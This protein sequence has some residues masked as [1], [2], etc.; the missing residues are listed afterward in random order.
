MDELLRAA[1]PALR[2][3][4]ADPYAALAFE[5]VGLAGTGRPPFPDLA[6]DMSQRFVEWFSDRVEY[7]DDPGA[8]GGAVLG[9]LLG[10]LLIHRIAG[11]A[12]ADAA[13]QYEGI[14]PP[15]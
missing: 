10:L 13:A 12:V 4:R 2:S 8:A 5:I 14:T 15:R 9:R 1:W 11:D 6:R 3:S 7:T